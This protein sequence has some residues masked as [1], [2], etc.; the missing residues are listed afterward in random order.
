MR[1]ENRYSEIESGEQKEEKIFFL[2]TTHNAQ[3]T[4]TRGKSKANK[5]KKKNK[6]VEKRGTL[7]GG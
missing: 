3:Q 5:H 4:T 1:A 6:R 7:D 2:G